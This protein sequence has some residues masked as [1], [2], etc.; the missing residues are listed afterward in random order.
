MSSGTPAPEY[1]GRGWAFPPRWSAS[2]GGPLGAEMVDGDDEVKQA[3]LILLRTGLRERTMHPDYGV[4]IDS[5]VF[6]E[7]TAETQTR[8]EEDIRRALIRFEPRV[9]VEKVVAESADEDSARIDVLIEYRVDPH[10][11]PDSLVFPFYIQ[12]GAPA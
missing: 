1:L 7:R 10:R 6:A 2:A 4:G 5:Y 12:A 8:L 3:I 9:V 11:R